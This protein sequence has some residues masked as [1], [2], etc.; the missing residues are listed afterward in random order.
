[1]IYAQEEEKY[2]LPRDYSIIGAFAGPTLMAYAK[3]DDLARFIPKMLSGEH[4]WC[5]L[6]S[7]P[8]AGSDLA[9]IRTRAE[10]DGDDWI[11]TGQKVWTSFAYM[12][13]WAIIVTRHD[14]TLPKHMGLTYFFMD[15]K[16]PGVEVV[17][18]KQVSGG[19]EFCEVF[20][21]EVRIPDAQRLGEIGHGG[22]VALTT[23]SNE[24]LDG[25][26]GGPPVGSL[27]HG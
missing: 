11:V 12:A 6:F 9:G 14:P 15:M 22:S 21:N 27:L 24:P 3:E 16:S 13:D 10:Q 20:L 25:G 5:Q 18:I 1:M 2:S 8:S 7:E 23:V 4:I 19:S 26:A 17:R